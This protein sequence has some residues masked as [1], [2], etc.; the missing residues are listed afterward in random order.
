MDEEMHCNATRLG[1]SAPFGLGKKKRNERRT[2]KNKQRGESLVV[3][4]S[5]KGIGRKNNDYQLRV[6][7][8]LLSIILLPSAA[9][10]RSTGGMGDTLRCRH[11]AHTSLR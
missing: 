4:V 6:F 2:N 9:E 8:L 7:Q 11:T 1:S 5:R 10:E 3:W